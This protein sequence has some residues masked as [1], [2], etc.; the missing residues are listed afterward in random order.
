MRKLVALA[1]AATF[2]TMPSVAQHQPYAA[3]A[4]RPIK[5][6]SAFAQVAG[7]AWL[8]QPNSIAIPGLRMFWRMQPRWV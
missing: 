2:Y 1:M 8:F 6:L 3:F 7:W 5:A 4:D